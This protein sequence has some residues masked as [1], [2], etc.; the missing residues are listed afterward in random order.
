ME[1]DRNILK[2]FETENELRK[3]LN[4]ALQEKGFL[5]ERFKQAQ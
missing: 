4:T 1:S 5:E 3:Q 2:Y